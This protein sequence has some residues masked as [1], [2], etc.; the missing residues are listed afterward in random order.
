MNNRCV[1]AVLGMWLPYH[2]NKSG[3]TKYEYRVRWFAILAILR[4]LSESDQIDFN[5]SVCEFDLQLV[6]LRML[7]R[8]LIMRNMQKKRI[9]K[10]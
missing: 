6:T 5:M 4:I 10:S 2:H 1:E 8:K 9:L 3:T 7:I